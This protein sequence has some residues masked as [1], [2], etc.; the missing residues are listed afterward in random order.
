MKR[1]IFIIF[2]GLITSCSETKIGEY[3]YV[4]RVSKGKRIHIDKNCRRIIC[5]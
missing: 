4:E 1:I 3:V 5:I 2:I